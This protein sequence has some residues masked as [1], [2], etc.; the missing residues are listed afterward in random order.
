MKT[1]ANSFNTCY[2]LSLMLVYVV[3]AHCKLLER[4]TGITHTKY[5]AKIVNG[6]WTFNFIVEKTGLE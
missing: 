6:F 1:E 5:A 4:D 3:E 2:N